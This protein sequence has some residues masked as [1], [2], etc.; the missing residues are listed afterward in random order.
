MTLFQDRHEELCKKYGC[1]DYGWGASFDVEW[2]KA[3]IGRV[4]C[5]LAALLSVNHTTRLSDTSIEVKFV[6]GYAVQASGEITPDDLRDQL[7][8]QMISIIPGKLAC[9]SFNTPRGQGIM[10]LENKE[11]HQ[12]VKDFL[13]NPVPVIPPDLLEDIRID[14]GKKVKSINKRFRN[15]DRETVRRAKGRKA[16][17][18]NSLSK[19]L[20]VLDQE[21]RELAVAALRANKTV[22][23]AQKFPIPALQQ[24]HNV[25]SAMLSGNNLQNWQD[26]DVIPEA[27]RLASVIWVMGQ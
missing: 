17:A 1:F 8:G 19:A 18:I 21:Y 20:S 25:I 12:L 10:P 22:L 14:L 6:D 16:R 7:L 15:R 24:L 27:E 3:E 11:A 23:S 4:Y 26:E 5:C 2:A 9:V 13:A